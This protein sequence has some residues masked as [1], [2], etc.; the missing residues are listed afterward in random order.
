MRT[1]APS[2]AAVLIALVV[3][4]AAA[5]SELLQGTWSG[6]G[7][8]ET[9][10][11]KHD[12]VRCRVSYDPQGSKVVAVTA[13]CTSGS[14]TIHQTG[15]LSLVNPNRYVGDFYNSEFDI[16][17]RI[18]VVVSGSSQTVTFSGARGHGRLNLSRN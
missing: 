14:T 11:G 4:P 7:Y 3:L 15:Q 9:T 17:G 10:E 8:V 2:A 5:R 16:S 13:S 1:I 12:S 6:G 18:R